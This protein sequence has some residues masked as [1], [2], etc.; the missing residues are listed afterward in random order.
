M[1]DEPEAARPAGADAAPRLPPRGAASPGGRPACWTI[2]TA[3][4]GT[5]RRSTRAPRWWT[6]SSA[7][8]S[9]PGRTQSRRP[10]PRCTRTPPRAEDTDWPQIAALYGAL[11]RLQP[12]PVIEL[13]RAVAVAMA[14]GPER[15]LE[16]LE[17]LEAPLRDYHLFHSAKAHL[18]R[19]LG[20]RRTPRP[21][22][23]GR[24][25]WPRTTWNAGSWS[26]GSRRSGP[27]PRR[28]TSSRTCPG[29]QPAG[30][31][32]CRRTRPGPC[33]LP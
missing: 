12:T 10:S 21:P 15:G 3:R 30:T 31:Y 9:R 2:R 5:G 26:G 27:S 33:R 1:P 20:R 18:L 8:G 16:V 14:E 6:R 23:A 24:S 17:P 22:T 19:Q 25:S 11:H 4:G 13:N 29:R 7:E 32:R 28:R